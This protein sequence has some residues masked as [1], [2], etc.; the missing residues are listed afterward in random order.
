MHVARILIISLLCAVSDFMQSQNET[1]KWYFGINAGLDFMTTPPSPLLNSAMTVLEGCSSMSDASGNLMFYTDGITVYNAAHQMMANGHSLFGHN[2]PAQSSIIIRKPGSSN[3]YYIFT[4][5]GAGSSLGLNYSIVNMSLAA[6]MGSVTAKNIPVYNNAVGERLTA[7]RHC[8]GV[9]Y[10]I[11]VREHS[12]FTNTNFRVYLLTSAGL[13]PNAII[14]PAN[15]SIQTQTN[16]WDIGCMKIS[17]NGKKLGLG[18]YSYQNAAINPHAFEL[19]DF[20]NSTG[21]IT[22]SLALNTGPSASNCGYGCEFSADGTKFYGG[23]IIS[24]QEKGLITQYDLCAGSPAAIAASEFSVYSFPLNNIPP[25]PGG[26]QLAKDGKIYISNYGGGYVTYVSV[27]HNPSATG[28]ACNF[29]LQSQSLN[30]RNGGYN[31]PN[32][33]GSQFLQPPPTAPFS[34]TS[35]NVYGC[36]GVQ[37][38]S[39]A[40]P[41][42]PLTNCAAMAFSL[43]SLAWD[44]GDPVSGPNNIS[45]QTNPVHVFSSLGIYTVQ[46]VLNY[47]C[48]GGSDTLRQI[49]NVNQSCFAVSTNSISCASLGSAT[50]QALVGTGPFSY[51]WFPAAQTGSV[52]TG[53][54]PG[55]YTVI[56]YD[57]GT[58]LSYSNALTFTSALSFTGNI[59]TATAVSCF[60]ATNGTASVTGLGGGSGQQYYSWCNGVQTFTSAYTNSLSAGIW[61][62]AITDA[63][64]NCSITQ[65]F[66]IAQPA[67]VNLQVSPGSAS[68]CAGANVTLTAIGIGGTPGSTL[69]Y[70]YQWTGGPSTNSFVAS[71]PVA[72]SVTY[73]VTVEDSLNCTAM[74]TVAVNYISN[75]IIAVTS[76]SIC[77]LASGSISASGASSY[78]WNTNTTGA[79]LVASPTVATV[80]TVTGTAQ[81]CSASAS[82]TI[83]LFPSPQPFATVTSPLCQNQNASFAATGGTICQ[84][85]GPNGFQSSQSSAILYNVTPSSSGNYTVKVTSINGCTASSIVNLTV[86]PTPTLIAVASTVCA[87]G[88]LQLQA[89]SF[90]GSTYTWTGPAGY[91]S[92]VQN[93]QIN[94][95][96]ATATGIYTVLALS[97][98]ACSVQASVHASVVVPPVV[99]TNINGP[100]CDGGTALFSAAGGSSYQWSG[101]GGFSSNQQFVTIN[102]AAVNASGVYTVTVSNG[103]C[104]VTSTTSLLVWTLPVVNP[105]VTPLVCETKSLGLIAG[106]TPGMA[107][108]LWQGPGGYSSLNVNPVRYNA[109]TAYSGDYTLTLKDGNGCINSATVPV[110]ILMNPVVTATGAT[111]CLHQPAVIS[112]SGAATYQWS[113]PGLFNASV[114]QATISSVSQAFAGVYTV[115]GTAA[116]TCTA[117]TTVSVSTLQLPVPIVAVAP[118]TLV[119]PGTL[120]SM[121]A[122][123][124][125][126]YDWFGPDDIY[127][128]GSLV[129]FTP[130]H[131][132]QQGTFTLVAED[133]AGCRNKTTFNIQLQT[134]PQGHIQ[135][136]PARGC[137]PL[138]TNFK[139]VS[140]SSNDLEFKF[141]FEQSHFSSDFSHC[142]NKPGKYSLPGFISDRKTGCSVEASTE[143]EV[144]AQPEAGFDFSPTDPDVT[145]FI[146]FTSTSQGASI[147]RFDWF[148]SGDV[149]ATATGPASTIN[150]SQPGEYAV[151]LVVTDQRNCSDTIIRKVMVTED[152]AAY[153]PNAFTP[154]GDRLNDWFQPVFVSFRKFDL[155]IFDRWGQLVYAGNQDQQGWDGTLKGIP[156]EQGTYTWIL[157]VTALD[158]KVRTLDGHINLFR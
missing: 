158:G 103:P 23:R 138:C 137:V 53:L 141:D 110:N 133:A 131:Q 79:L 135:P 68:T 102:N 4:V 21:V 148:F 1:S 143:V 118:G 60:G 29:S 31:M 111:V 64:T 59:N 48:G 154:N 149:P 56:V 10:W 109:S 13:S 144:Y 42:V 89:M 65:S 125:L 14:S 30:G 93:P 7:T 108:Y 157:Q 136:E 97:P 104:V 71:K 39:P 101:P 83:G 19:Y 6:G 27:I 142:F 61:S 33:V 41:N 22:N 18:L 124:G 132:G 73:T 113:G 62:V 121:G 25:S 17:P 34:Y 26:L 74:Q 130:V 116:N 123:G 66:F 16:I 28:A 152:F 127:L 86:H 9:D 24:A 11:V 84:W 146:E 82:G 155:K 57:A 3:L 77:P 54:F 134:L 36:Q 151:A 140:K 78:T 87:T 37:F 105:S 122:K 43:V 44:F 67:P 91:Y 49:V 5:A 128:Q 58:N 50:V 147:Q 76:T 153:I 38:S 145:Q 52:A 126:R 115:T 106:G 99:T 90:A 95:P 98:G 70:N 40:V 107:Q 63:V 139:M 112:A 88:N 69:P 94:L 20:D 2:T 32:F 75:P 81:S 129:D 47:S 35:S 72:G 51:S 120:L 46:L 55:T 80:Y 92:F 96:S 114:Q 85:S 150:Y 119:C 8:N 15:N 12:N 156:C 117:V 45:F 100:F